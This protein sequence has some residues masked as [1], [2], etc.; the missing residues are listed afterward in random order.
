MRSVRPRPADARKLHPKFILVNNTLIL[1]IHDCGR[2]QDRSRD[3]KR[4]SAAAGESTAE[5]IG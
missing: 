3:G 2:V 1:L 4:P 5:V